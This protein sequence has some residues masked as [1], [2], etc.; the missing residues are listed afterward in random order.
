VKRVLIV[1]DEAIV[2]DD[3]HYQV[4][5][6]GYEVA[7]IADSGLEAIALTDERA[8]EII[9]MDIQLQGKMTG[10]EAAQAI[11]RRSR[12]AI[13][14]ITAFAAMYA[15]DSNQVAK[16]S[17]CLSKPFSLAQLNSALM[18]ASSQVSDATCQ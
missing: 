11:Q 16:P 17:I 7:G 3:L 8:P 1:E 14:F 12:A 5:Q 15:R 9:L 10:M 13:I 4:V 18:A 2:A 6:L